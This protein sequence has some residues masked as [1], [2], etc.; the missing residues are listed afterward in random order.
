MPRSKP[1]SRGGRIS[2]DRDLDG[3]LQRLD[4]PALQEDGDLLV[5]NIDI[6]NAG[7]LARHA[8][9]QI[10][11]PPP[12]LE[13]TQHVI[14]DF[15]RLE[16]YQM[17]D[18][19][20]SFIGLRDIENMRSVSIFLRNYIDNNFLLR[21]SLPLPSDASKN[22]GKRKVLAIT[23][24]CNLTW[25]PGI[26]T[27]QPF[28]QLN[29]TNLREMKLIGKNCDWRV[30]S[31][32][33]LSQVYHESLQHLIKILSET[34]SLRKLE[35]LTD[36]TE[37]SLDTADAIVKLVNLEELVLHGIYYFSDGEGT[38]PTPAEVPNLIIQHALLNRNVSKLT[39]IQ[40]EI[41]PD[42]ALIVNSD[43]L[44]ELSILKC[45]ST[46]LDLSLSSLTSLETDI[47]MIWDFD[48][49]EKKRM[50]TMVEAG[51]PQL[52]VWNEVNVQEVAE[53]A[54]STTW[55]EHLV[56]PEDREDSSSDS[57]SE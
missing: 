28:T 14:F 56:L 44:T 37:R 3:R 1:R 29:L 50:K 34:A 21:L 45:K 19:V 48:G 17:L 10:I 40:F 47:S 18:P 11:L 32:P 4:S 33:V 26:N 2:W 41:V 36:V 12:G 54:E 23:S 49:S 7:A 55:A 24:C 39:L 35:I 25:L 57:D 27:L 22:L 51:C 42:E 5:Y 20:L 38:Q 46:Q 16:R 13:F 31:P 53:Q 15:E 9:D 30:N 6:V 52:L 43:T 8:V